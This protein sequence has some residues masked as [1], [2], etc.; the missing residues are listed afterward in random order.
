MSSIQDDISAL[1][2]GAIDCHIHGSPDVTQR[3][4]SDLQLARDAD[5][6][7]MRAI[8][9]KSHVTPTTSRACLVQEAVGTG[10]K[11]FGGLTLNRQIG[12]L[13]VHAVETELR[14]GA[15]EI[16][17]PTLSAVNQAKLHNQDLKHTVA[18]FDEQDNPLPQL[19]D[20]LDL[21]SKYNA[22][23]THQNAS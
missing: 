10:F 5:A 16:W 15:K 20:I 8:L 12:G 4:A 13:N 3:I 19:I 17:M 1:M 22:I 7:G 18:I 23:S 2:K 9:V 6:V 21:I 11:V 14:L